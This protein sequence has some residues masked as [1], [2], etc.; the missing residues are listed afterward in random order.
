MRSEPAV[1]RR[2]VSSIAVALCLVPPALVL[3]Q[4]TLYG[5][6]ADPV[7]RLTNV[8]GLWSLRL[9]LATLAI[10]PL[11][12][13]LGCNWLMPA[14]RIL[15]LFA[16]FYGVLHLIVYL[17]LN[18][19]LS[20]T[21]ILGDLSRPF[22]I[23]GYLSLLLMAPLAATSTVRSMRRLGARWQRLHRLVYLVAIL[24]VLH[25]LLLVKID[26]RPPEVYGAALSVLLLYRVAVALRRRLPSKKAP[27]TPAIAGR[28]PE[29]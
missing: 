24:G 8:T 19:T 10:T 11:R 1:P 7:A 21:L 26:F 3:Y 14:R 25:Y 29:G 27:G 4:A 9:L 28:S 20:P 6:G 15:G 22:I 17:V 16:F 18:Q 13:M 12:R 23:A 5:L 2:V